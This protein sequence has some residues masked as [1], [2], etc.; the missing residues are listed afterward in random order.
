MAGPLHAPQIVRMPLRTGLVTALALTCF[1]ANSLLCRAALRPGLVDPATFTAVRVASGAAVLAVLV[2]AR[3][4]GE[5]RQGSW[6]SAASLFA[7]AAAFS[8]AYVRLHAG[9]G[10]LL[11]FAAVQAT[12]LGWSLRAG[13]TLGARQWLGVAIA[14]AGLVL[15]TAP[16]AASPGLAGAG[17]MVAAG[18]AWGVYSIRGRSAVDPV[19]TTAGNFV[20]ALPLAVAWAIAS[21]AS[22]R[23][24]GTGLALAAISGAVTSGGGYVLWYAALP[25]LGAARAATLQLAVPVLAAAA[26]VLLLG[27]PLTIRLVLAAAAIVAGIALAVRAR[28]GPSTQ[29]RARP[30]P[31]EAAPSR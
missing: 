21:A 5:L 31:L 27:E 2:L 25:V 22:S 16:G 10:A 1:A 19:A 18:V 3:G 23:T 20:R 12:M 15:L 4:K 29:Q 11:L 7:Y 26:G 30:E 9:T 14:A 24:S 28:G 6:G 13:V 8:L 17:L